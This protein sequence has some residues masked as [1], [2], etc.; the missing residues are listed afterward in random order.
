MP[1]VN[2]TQLFKQCLFYEL[3]DQE[4]RNTVW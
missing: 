4:Q 2:G 3:L 1:N